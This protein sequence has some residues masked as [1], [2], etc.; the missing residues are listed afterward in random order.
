MTALNTAF[1]YRGSGR[2]S[3]RY[4]DRTFQRR[5]NIYCKYCGEG[6]FHWTF[7][8]RSWKLENN[9]HSIHKCSPTYTYVRS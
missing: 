1:L 5:M 4:P 7:K 3:Y 6:P 2:A 8:K 9:S